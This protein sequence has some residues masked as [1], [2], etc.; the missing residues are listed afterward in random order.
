MTTGRQM[1]IQYMMMEQVLLLFFT[2]YLQI[3]LRLKVNIDIRVEWFNIF[4]SVE[5][6]NC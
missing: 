2:Y 5:Y 6:D 3:G 1:R 4:I